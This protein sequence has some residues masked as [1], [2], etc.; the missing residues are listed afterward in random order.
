MEPVVGAKLTDMAYES[1]LDA[2]LEAGVG[3]WDVVAAAERKGSLDSAIKAYQANPLETAL[4]RFPSLRTLAFNGGKA[5][6]IG[7]KQLAAN[8]DVQLIPLPSSSAAYCAMPFEEK[9]TRW[10]GLMLSLS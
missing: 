2:L 3:L 9:R 5:Y 1:K 7:R 4:H 6:Q 8:N 10:S